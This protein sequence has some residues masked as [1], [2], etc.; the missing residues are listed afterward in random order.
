V[1]L[2][3]G[4]VGYIAAKYT[5][6]SLNNQMTVAKIKGEWKIISFFQQMGC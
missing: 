3:G 4:K 5:S 6:S 2:K 1:K